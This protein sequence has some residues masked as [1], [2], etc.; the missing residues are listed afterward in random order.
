MPMFMADI[1]HT[2]DV[3]NSLETFN[4]LVDEE[5]FVVS[6]IYNSTSRRVGLS[7]GSILNNIIKPEQTLQNEDSLYNLSDILSPMISN[8]ISD[9]VIS[10]NMHSLKELLDAHI[11]IGGQIKT[12]QFLCFIADK[13]VEYPNNKYIYLAPTLS[14]TRYIDDKE[15][16]SDFVCIDLTATKI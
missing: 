9:A 4:E 8:E 10:G 12:G 16:C 13:Y 6:N 2:D 1:T 14:H 5:F 11:Y 7:L 15:E 3:L